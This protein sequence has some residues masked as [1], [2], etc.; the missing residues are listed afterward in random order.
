M[1][2]K[3]FMFVLFAFGLLFV[4]NAYAKE[5][6]VYDDANKLFF[7]NGTAITISE[8]TDGVSGATI[9][10]DGG[11]VN[12][13]EGVSVFGAA[14]ESDTVYDSTSIVMNGG[15][16][17]N[18][19]G[20]GLHK[21]EVKTTNIT[22]NGGKVTSVNGGGGASFKNTTCHRPWFDG[23]GN[24][25]PTIVLKSNITI[26]GGNI[27]GVFGGGEGISKTQEANVFVNGGKM[28]YVIAGGSN[29]FTGD[30]VVTVN[31]GEINTLQ[32][33]NR[34]SMVT[35]AITVEGGK[36]K[37]AYVAGDSS[38]NEVTGTIKGAVMEINGGEVGGL[39][40]GSNGGPNVSAKDV[41]TATYKDG[42]VTTLSNDFK[43]G[44]VSTTIK[45]TF[46]GGEDDDV[47][48]ILIPKGT[49]FTDD[50]LNEIISNINALLKEENLELDGFYLD[51]DYTQKFDMTSEFSSDVT[52]YV[53]TKELLQEGEEVK[54]PETSDINVIAL[55]SLITLG[56]IGLG[57][58]V[59]K[60]KFN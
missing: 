8:R 57:Y 5:A 42:T 27:W 56:T 53:K 55:I 48:S 21:S 24:E 37:N 19:I 13:P 39:Y 16:V 60:R 28:T 41:V 49:K 58:T 6:P 50:Q 11:S 47:D 46:V 32:A 12:T 44:T 1:K 10:W 3:L 40:P 33:V 4:P 18:I 38:D 30:S 43:E 9:T 7:A 29:G 20:G 25:S 22:I 52:V 35:S 23:K 54:N 51:E 17:K 15:V 34:G 2:K 14:H 36:I 59:K 31:G 45:L 26:N